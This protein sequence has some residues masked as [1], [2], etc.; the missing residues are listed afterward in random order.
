MKFILEIELGNDAM[1]SG[2][3][4]GEALINEGRK[5]ASCWS[6]ELLRKGDDARIKDINGDTI[7]SWRIEA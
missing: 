1:E 3:D 6:E 4:V 5:L 7:G 2:S